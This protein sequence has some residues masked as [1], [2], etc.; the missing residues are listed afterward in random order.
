[1]VYVWLCM[2]QRR[3]LTCCIVHWHRVM[4]PGRGGQQH[5]NIPPLK[6][7]VYENKLGF[8]YK[9]HLDVSS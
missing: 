5:I 3:M 2:E 4:I 8:Q 7:Y 1:M 9:V 6:V